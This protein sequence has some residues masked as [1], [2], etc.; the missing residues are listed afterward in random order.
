M[1]GI[2]PILQSVY[3]LGWCLLY[4]LDDYCTSLS[5]H[6]KVKEMETYSYHWLVSLWGCIWTFFMSD[7]ITSWW[8]YVTSLISCLRV[9]ISWDKAESPIELSDWLLHSL[10]LAQ[11][12]VGVWSSSLLIF[13]FLRDSPNRKRTAE[14]VLSLFLTRNIWS[15]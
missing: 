12:P 7:R 11:H 13:F 5:W 14:F 1:K 3:P 4:A 6:L 2:L 8:E 10:I 9:S 15:K